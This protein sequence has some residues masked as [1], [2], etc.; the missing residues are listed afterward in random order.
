[1][2]GELTVVYVAKQRYRGV[3]GERGISEGD[4]H[5]EVGEGLELRQRRRAPDHSV[6][7]F[8]DYGFGMM[9]WGF[10]MMV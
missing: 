4:D 8:R 6:L 9:V 10:G 3:A 2:C 1:M 7:E 5:Q